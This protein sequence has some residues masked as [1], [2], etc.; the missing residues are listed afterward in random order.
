MHM[1]FRRYP[2]A[3]ALFLLLGLVAPPAKADTTVASYVKMEKA[4]QADLL[5]RLLQSL[6]EDL[7]ANNRE[8]EAECLSA[9]YTVHSE[10]REARS[11][12][13]A[14]FLQSVAF[15]QKGDPQRITIE[16]IIV[17]QM[18]QYC[19]AKAKKKK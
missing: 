15:A 19:G 8:K 12:G 2:G 4:A 7:Q 10:A 9:L 1:R 6:A 3:L 11:P 16:E 5:G 17:H 18:A 13:M 14:D